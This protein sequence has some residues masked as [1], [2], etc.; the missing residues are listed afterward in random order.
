MIWSL[1][2][3]DFND[4]CYDGVFPVLNTIKSELQKPVEQVVVVTSGPLSSMD[5]MLVSKQTKAARKN[6]NRLKVTKI[7][8]AGVKTTNPTTPGPF[9]ETK[10]LTN[11]KQTKG[12][13]RQPKKQQSVK[14]PTQ[15]SNK[16]GNKLGQGKR[17]NRPLKRRPP[18]RQKQ[19][20]KQ[21]LAK[22]EPE[23]LISESTTPPNKITAEVKTSLDIQAEITENT[24]KTKVT[25][26]SDT[27]NKRVT[28][29]A[30][31][32]QT[33]KPR[34]TSKTNDQK[35][36]AKPKT[37]PKEK[38]TRNKASVKAN[39]RNGRK[40]PHKLTPK[41]IQRRRQFLKMRRMKLAVKKRKEA[42][43]KRKLTTP[44]P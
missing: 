11:S 26:K 37:K 17:M 39:A 12:T 1:D 7:T 18:T 40:R 2:T 29:A 10:S 14:T 22:T 41:Q 24:Q 16:T 34:T 44:N 35:T 19:L 8:K 33:S 36:S 9:E 23:K 43:E 3:D 21:K 28:P 15:N 31:K 25:S 38:N 5:T 42:E 27:T 32:I 4:K 20:P 30:N 6:S 13:T